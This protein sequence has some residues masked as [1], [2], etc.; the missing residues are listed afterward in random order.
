MFVYPVLDYWVSATVLGLITFIL[1]NPV[2]SDP[3]AIP[4][5]RP[6]QPQT[7]VPSYPGYLPHPQYGYQPAPHMYNEHP[8][9]YQQHLQHPQQEMYAQPPELSPTPVPASRV[10]EADGTQRAVELQ[11]AQTPQPRR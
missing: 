2:W 10:Y 4:D 7:F 1:R 11:G 9:M 8:Q 3:A 5:R 6:E